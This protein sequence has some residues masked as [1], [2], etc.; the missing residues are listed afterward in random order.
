M[1]QNGCS[2]G[3]EDSRGPI[4]KTCCLQEDGN[5][6]HRQAGNASYSKKI[7]NT[8]RQLKLHLDNVVSLN[9]VLYIYFVNLHL[10]FE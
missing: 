9:L 1:N 2:T 7:R 6:C 4:E 8:V 10:F 5:R 3:E